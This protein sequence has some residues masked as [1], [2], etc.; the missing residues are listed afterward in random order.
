MVV[1]DPT[2]RNATSGAFQIRLESRDEAQSIRALIVQLACISCRR[3]YLPIGMFPNQ[4]VAGKLDNRLY[5]EDNFSRAAL[6]HLV[7]ESEISRDMVVMEYTGVIDIGQNRRPRTLV[8]LFNPRGGRGGALSSRGLIVLLDER[9]EEWWFAGDNSKDA[10]DTLMK[11]RST[12]YQSKRGERA[13]DLGAYPIEHIQFI[14][15]SRTVES[16]M[17]IVFDTDGGTARV[18]SLSLLFASSEARQ[19][20]YISIVKCRRRFGMLTS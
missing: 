12:F 14:A 16:T 17:T 11:R 13:R 7:K 3:R 8:V 18:R 1:M 15:L 4:D 19:R 2:R 5:S 6:A 9:L 20:A 10:G